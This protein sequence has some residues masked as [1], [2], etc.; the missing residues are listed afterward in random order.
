MNNAV[1]W[2]LWLT[3]LV[4]HS[5]TLR[6]GKAISSKITDCKRE[7][8]ENLLLHNLKIKLKTSTNIGNQCKDK[9]GVSIKPEVMFS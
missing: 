7:K 9:I 1:T 8:N 3:F 4:L 6:S 5:A 2:K